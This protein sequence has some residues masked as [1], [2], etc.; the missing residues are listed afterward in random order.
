MDAGI[1][2]KDAQPGSPRAAS[3]SARRQP[4]FGRPVELAVSLIDEDPLQ[5]RSEA[6][7]GFQLRSLQEL[8]STICQRGVKSPIS[9]RHDPLHPGRYIVNHGAR[10][11]RASKLAGKE[12][13]PAFV[14]D[15]HSDA[16]QVVE[17]LQRNE[18][19]PREIADYIGRE[20]SRGRK[21]SEVAKSIGK[22]AAF[23]TQHVALL[24]LPV[25]IARAFNAG[26]VRDVTVVSELVTCYKSSPNDVARWLDDEFQEVTRASV[27]LFRKFVEEHASLMERGGT[28]LERRP[29]AG[30]EPGQEG[31]RSHRSASA[32]RIA[33]PLVRL[34]HGGRV[35]E[36]LLHH[37]PTREGHAW[38][39]YEDDGIPSEVDLTAIRVLSL[40][41]RQ[42]RKG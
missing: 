2:P 19:T 30:S 6:N 9:V 36:L 11:L 25:P 39:R 16:D 37:L 13:I 15:D 35:G 24:D 8:A 7:P 5:P 33:S 38:I 27:K 41:E 32:K 21:R 34:E 40:T 22:S 18:L 26:R 31:A 28:D 23:V 20:L 14:D 12:T 3:A 29:I 10:R 4:V 42:S 17:N 1:I